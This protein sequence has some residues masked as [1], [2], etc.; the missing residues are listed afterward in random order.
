MSRQRLLQAPVDGT[1]MSECD[2]EQRMQPHEPPTEL[3]SETAKAWGLKPLCLL[4]SVAQ[5]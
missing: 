4:P 2:P 1:S 5:P 3:H